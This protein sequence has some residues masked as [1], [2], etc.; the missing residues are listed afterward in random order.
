MNVTMSEAVESILSECS[1]R[2]RERVTLESAKG[3]VLA[4]DIVSRFDIPSQPKCAID[5][6]TFT[7]D[8]I[9]SFP[10]VLKIV[11]ESRAGEAFEKRV[12][13]G[14]A[15]FTMTGAVVPEG[16]DTAVRIEDVKV[17]GERLYIERAP[18]KGDLI[19][20]AGSE[21]GRGEKILRAGTPLGYREVS[22]L[23]NM[24]HYEISVYTRPRIGIVSTGD[25]ILEAWEDGEAV[26][27]RNSNRYILE[28]ML[29]EFA[30]I[31]Y[32]AKVEDKPSEMLPIFKRA[33]SECDILLSSGGASRGKYDFTRDI[34]SSLGLEISFTS[35]NIRPGRPLIFAHRED[36]LFFGLPGYPAALLV[37][38]IVF[39]LPAVK[40]ICGYE[41]F[42]NSKFSAIAGEKLKA[43]RGRNDFL[44]VNLNYEKGRV[45]AY[46]AGSQQTSNFLTMSRCDALA[47]I[48]ENRGEVE[49]G[50][51]IEIF[52]LFG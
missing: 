4:E 9:E 17:E 12:G 18:R 30:D 23:A 34:A 8:S 37:N 7:F 46:S 51:E 26:A 50:E 6:F 43:K 19:N 5:G 44:R 22:L 29:E 33:L 36:K 16:A 39:L 28:G 40:K 48:D 38:A 47:I 14:E 27:V 31:V 11:G 10:A 41:K 42:E 3:R 1:A 20:E 25:E 21:I 2:F 45:F 35:T 15:V 32:Y 52:H 13:P 49:E 24:G